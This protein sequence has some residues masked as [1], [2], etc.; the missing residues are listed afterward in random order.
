MSGIYVMYYTRA[1]AEIFESFGIAMNVMEIVVVFKELRK[2]RVVGCIFVVQKDSGNVFFF[3]K[4][5]V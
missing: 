2:I 4:G 1:A 5:Y 3:I